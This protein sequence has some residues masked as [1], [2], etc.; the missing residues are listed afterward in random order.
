M[1]AP[2]NIDH[3]RKQGKNKSEIEGTLNR[4]AI[5]MLIIAAVVIFAMLYT[6]FT[7]PY[8]PPSIREVTP[9][10]RKQISYLKDKYKL[11]GYCWVIDRDTGKISYYRKGQWW[12]VR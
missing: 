11:H 2:L 12:T 3:L 8:P 5:A 1:T 10:E 9:A 4:F 6:I 7:R